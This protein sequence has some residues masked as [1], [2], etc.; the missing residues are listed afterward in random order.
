MTGIAIDSALLDA[1]LASVRPLVLGHGG[2]IAIAGVENGVV[3][4]ELGGACEACPNKA[5]TYAGPVRT[6]LLDVPG[7]IEVRCRRVHASARALNRIA[8]ALGARPFNR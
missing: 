3:T 8:L 6:A 5:M 2:T 4:V 1:A 7:V